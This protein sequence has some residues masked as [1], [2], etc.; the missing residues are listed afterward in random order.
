VIIERIER[1]GEEKKRLSDDIA[2]VYSD[3]KGNGYVVK[4]LRTIVR[5]LRML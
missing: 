2:D 1:F 5:G 4:A 3:A